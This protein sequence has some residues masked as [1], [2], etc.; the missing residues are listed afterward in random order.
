M[1]TPLSIAER[2]LG[3]VAGITRTGFRAAGGIVTAVRGG[4]SRSADDAPPK[5]LLTDAAL[6]RKVESELFRDNAVPKGK[7]VVNA[8]GRVVYLRGQARS[9]AMIADL[10]VRAQAIP[11][12]ERVENLLESPRTRQTRRRRPAR[13][14]NAE[15]PPATPGAEP[16]P[17]ELAAKGKGRRAAP[18]GSSDPKKNGGDTAK[19][20]RS[21]GSAT[22]RAS[23]S[24]RPTA[25]K[26]TAEVPPTGPKAE[27]S[28]KKLAAKG[29]GR[30]AAPLGSSEP[31]TKPG[32]NTGSASR[33]RK[34]T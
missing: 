5:P 27:P 20:R 22:K 6:A 4:S 15:A 32:A 17:K 31:K 25:R 18:L 29:Q 12:V 33:R 26:V 1:P 28:P 13:R 11:E 23:T 19:T 16:S 30:R 14:V 24:R 7:I 34:A 2:S 21:K 9:A 3:V 8:V 10:S